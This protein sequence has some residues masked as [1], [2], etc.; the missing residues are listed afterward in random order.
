MSVSVITL[1]WNGLPQLERCLPAV[2]PQL[3]RSDQLILVDNGSSDGSATWVAARYPSV[4]L[5]R[6]PTNVGFAAAVNQG[7]R[8]ADSEWVVALNDDTVVSPGWLDALLAAAQS[9]ASVGMVACKMRLAGD[10]SRFDSAGIVVDRA[11]IAW[12]RWYGEPVSAHPITEPEAV[13]GPCGGAA[14]YRRAMLDQI[15]LFDEDFFAY[16]EDVD[17]AWRARRAGWHCLYSPGADVVHVHSA[18]GNRVTGL[19][20]YL[21]GRNKWWTILKNYPQPQLWL[22]LPLILAYDLTAALVGC[23][24]DRRLDALRGRRDALRQWRRF[25]QKRTPDLARVPLAPPRLPGRV[26]QIARSD[27]K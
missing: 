17:L 4:H 25:W 2:C 1:T 27:V 8:A 22:A 10:S 21:L 15:G 7:I 9:D 24:Q 3:G 11:G 5:I 14:L 19:K 23:L 18:T 20:R 13:F 26:R 12:N 6:N 16:Y